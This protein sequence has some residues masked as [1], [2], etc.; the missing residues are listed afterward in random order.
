MPPHSSQTL[1]ESIIKKKII[2]KTKPTSNTKVAV[3]N[4]QDV[5]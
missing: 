1:V 2:Y 5:T 4:V 3:N